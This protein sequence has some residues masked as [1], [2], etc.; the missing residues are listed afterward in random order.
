MTFILFS[1]HDLYFIFLTLW[2]SGTIP[3]ISYG[4]P[5]CDNTHFKLP[6][7]LSFYCHCKVWNSDLTWKL[8][9]LCCSV[10]DLWRGGGLPPPPSEGSVPESGFISIIDNEYIVAYNFFISC[11]YIYTSQWKFSTCPKGCITKVTWHFYLY[12]FLLLPFRLLSSVLL[13]WGF[14][15]NSLTISVKGAT[16][17][18]GSHWIET[19]VKFKY[20]FSALLT[21][22]CL[23]ICALA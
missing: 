4:E 21:V 12:A 3:R 13:F 11:I 6:M 18:L 14:S 10:K 5:K 16:F 17:G 9:P 23:Q 15:L 20:E 8:G 22:H 7:P 2:F 19:Y 1:Q